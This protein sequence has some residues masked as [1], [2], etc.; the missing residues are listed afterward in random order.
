MLALLEQALADGTWPIGAR[1]PAESELAAQFGISKNTV[2]EAVSALVQQ[3]RLSRQQGRGTFVVAPGPAAVAPRVCALFVQTRGHV[4]DPQTKVLVRELQRRGY[5]PMLFDLIDLK[6]DADPEAA[7]EVLARAAAAGLQ[8]IITEGDPRWLIAAT[9][10]S[11]LTCPPIWVINSGDAPPMPG[12]HFVLTD[13]VAGPALATR[14][15]LALGHERILL[16]VH[17]NKWGPPGEAPGS[18]RGRY[19]EMVRG[20]LEALGPQ[21]QPHLMLLDHELNDPAERQALDTLLR[22]ADRP[23]AVLALSDNR[24]KEVAA[25]ALAA[26]LRIPTDLA[27]VGYYNTPWVAHLAV[28]L[29]SVS[30]CEETIAE[31]TVRWL[32]G[33][34]PTEQTRSGRI[35]VP[36][37]LVVRDSCGGH[38]D[39]ADPEPGPLLIKEEYPG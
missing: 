35:I 3:G 4:Y 39:S 1:L 25:I 19:H 36:P 15:L 7:A 9:Q 18:G 29:S 23:T 32:A 24:A 22:A 6:P 37:E 17:R 28:P 31:L 27:V 10:A 30:I 38:R 14:H 2:R 11:G 8:A 5:S 13:F 20:Y 21:R 34:L 26:G 12:C 16:V 33:E